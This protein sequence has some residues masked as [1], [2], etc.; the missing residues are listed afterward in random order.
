M[1]LIHAF[2]LVAAILFTA[3]AGPSIVLEKRNYGLS[4][5]TSPSGLIWDQSGGACKDK[6]L[7]N[8]AIYSFLVDGDGD[9]PQTYL[10]SCIECFWKSPQNCPGVVLGRDKSVNTYNKWQIT[11]IEPNNPQS[12]RFAMRTLDST[13]GKH[14]YV[15]GGEIVQAEGGQVGLVTEVQAMYEWRYMIT[16]DCRV[17]IY[18]PD[19]NSPMMWCGEWCK[20]WNVY[21]V[22]SRYTVVTYGDAYNEN[23]ASMMKLRTSWNM[24]R[25][26]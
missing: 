9:F 10:S 13:N 2:V 4:A 6:I 19:N 12:N 23:S 16:N 25:V 7:V 18:R 5:S 17:R 14:F 11:L 26:G 22:N 20:D 24:Q 15:G 1:Q 21:S 8:G 3:E